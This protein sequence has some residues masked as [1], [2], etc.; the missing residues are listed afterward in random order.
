MMKKT[1]RKSIDEAPM[2]E[3][4]AKI[5]KEAID[6]ISNKNQRV[7]RRMIIITLTHR[8]SS[9]NDKELVKQIRKLIR[10]ILKH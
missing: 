6:D 5:M 10:L 3:H 1:K 8:Y 7:T 2:T 9:E 4:Q